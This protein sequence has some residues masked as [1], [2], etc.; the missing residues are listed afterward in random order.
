MLDGREESTEWE[1]GGSAPL[2]VGGLKG[3][4]ELDGRVK[5]G[6]EVEP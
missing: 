5:I 4:R 6:W 3:K 1:V 2:G